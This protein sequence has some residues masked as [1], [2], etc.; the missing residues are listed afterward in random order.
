[1]T[2]HGK[3]EGWED[4]ILSYIEKYGAIKFGDDEKA[5]DKITIK[6]VQ[7]LV[8]I[9]EEISKKFKQNDSLEVLISSH[10]HQAI[11]IHSQ[12]FKTG[13]F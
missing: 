12:K 6:M 7:A 3:T 8:E 1:M 13:F 5:R 9:G 2:Q 10:N 11:M 4:A